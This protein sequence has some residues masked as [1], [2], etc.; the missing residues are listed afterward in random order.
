MEQATEQAQELAHKA[1]EQASNMATEW[2]VQMSERSIQMRDRLTSR[3]R[4]LSTELEQMAS[5]PTATGATTGHQV[6]R[7]GAQMLRRTAASL[8]SREPGDWIVEVRQ[9]ARE[10]PQ[11]VMGALFLTGLVLGRIGRSPSVAQSAHPQTVDLRATEP[12]F[13]P[14]AGSLPEPG[15]IE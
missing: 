7:Q 3:M 15:Y 13:E 14:I 4:S 10:H 9:Y 1:S 8:D 6:A 2:R 5:T 12:S 11:R